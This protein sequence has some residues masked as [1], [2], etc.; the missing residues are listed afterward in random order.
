LQSFGFLR[1]HLMENAPVTLY[2]AV[3]VLESP[4]AGVPFLSKCPG[5]SVSLIALSPIQNQGARRSCFVSFFCT[6]RPGRGRLEPR[7]AACGIRESARN[8][9]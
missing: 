7:R 5:H 3:F 1:L 2:R 9:P 6:C 8:A 4:D